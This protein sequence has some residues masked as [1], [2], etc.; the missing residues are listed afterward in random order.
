[1]KKEWRDLDLPKREFMYVSGRPYLP[2]EPKREGLPY[3]LTE[4]RGEEL[5]KRIGEVVEVCFDTS[6]RMI[7]GVM[8]KELYSPFVSFS[9]QLEDAVRVPVCSEGISDPMFTVWDW[10]YQM[11]IAGT[12]EA[13]ERLDHRRD[14]H[15][16]SA[17]AFEHGTMHWGTERWSCL[18]IEILSQGETLIRT[19]VD[20][21]SPRTKDVD[22]RIIVGLYSHIPDRL[23]TLRRE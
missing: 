21:F 3:V 7:P 1:M 6:P 13:V 8:M 4:A 16:D 5:R 9:G 17:Y 11:K 18:T 22:S 14:A 10:V 15:I 12:K 23:K 19:D 20:I 2:L